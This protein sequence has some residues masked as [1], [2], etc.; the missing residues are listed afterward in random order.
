VDERKIDPDNQKIKLIKSTSFFVLAAFL[1]FLLATFRSQK[2]T[3]IKIIKDF[4]TNIP[5]IK[6][7][8][9]AKESKIKVVKVIDGD[10][11]ELENGQKVRYIG[12]DTP[13]LVHPSK[14]VECFAKEAQEKNKELVL[15]KEV[16]LEKDIS[17]T[18][19]YG[20]LLRYVWVNDIL[21]NEVLVQE[22]YAQVSTY[23]P[24]VKYQERF[25]EAQRKAREENKGLW[26][27][28]QY[29]GQKV[30]SSQAEKGCLIKG[31]ISASGEKIYHLT[32]CGSYHKT[33]INESKGEKWFCSEKE[34][35]FAGFRK[36][37]NC[38]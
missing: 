30:L 9:K 1:A 26:S 11:I 36:A 27:S 31:N 8:T 15:G 3:N 17:E 25:L 38:P 23:P 4:K 10:T 12:I 29:F 28:C 18:D 16:W 19:K 24:D 21:V 13:E 2:T 34:A 20:R 7:K 5:E 33:V 32:E 35:I 6:E 22:G 37:K 14:P